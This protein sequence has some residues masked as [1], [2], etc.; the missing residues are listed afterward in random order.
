M[1]KNPAPL[2]L[3]KSRIA[4]ASLLTFEKA[5]RSLV[6]YVILLDA[7]LTACLD[8]HFRSLAARKPVFIHA[9]LMKGVSPDRDGLQFLK[10]SVGIQGIVSTR[11]PVLK[12]AQGLGLLTIQR[13]FLIDTSSLESALEALA[14]TQP[15]AV[16]FM[17]GIAPGIL[18]YIKGR[19]E[20]PL[21]SAG[22]IRSEADIHQ[23]F[24]AGADAV[25]MSRVELWEVPG[26]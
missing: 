16:E 5:I 13:T 12:T 25:S 17:P 2:V 1:D 18:S 20:F 8:G 24:E 6:P 10:N 7:D 21:I 26:V 9:D 4:A 23:A 14:K 11:S 19:I 22:L 15:S 3:K